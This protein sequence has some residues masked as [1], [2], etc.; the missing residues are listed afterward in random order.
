MFDR[1][2]AS[3]FEVFMMIM[4]LI[5]LFQSIYTNI[6]TKEGYFHT[7]ALKSTQEMLRKLL[8]RTVFVRVFVT[9]GINE[10][11]RVRYIIYIKII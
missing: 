4:E 8:V 9:Q 3:I 2:F 1:E 10:C 11:Y 5:R 6:R 7:A